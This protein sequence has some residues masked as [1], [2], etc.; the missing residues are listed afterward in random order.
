MPGPSPRS[1]AWRLSFSITWS[2][3]YNPAILWR[4]TSHREY[5][6]QSSSAVTIRASAPAPARPEQSVGN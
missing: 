2:T 5:C 6:G 1:E 4:I 3:G